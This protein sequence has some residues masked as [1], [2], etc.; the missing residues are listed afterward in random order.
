MRFLAVIILSAVLFAS[1][2]PPVVRAQVPYP[3]PPVTAPPP[4]TPVPPP[5]PGQQFAC[6]IFGGQ[7]TTPTFAPVTIGFQVFYQ[8]QG[9]RYWGG[10]AVQAVPFGFYS[11]YRY[12]TAAPSL[13]NGWQF[14]AGPGIIISTDAADFF[15]V[16]YVP[17]VPIY[18]PP[19]VTV[20]PPYTQPL[21]GLPAPGTPAPPRTPTGVG[22][23]TLGFAQG[24]AVAGWRLQYASGRTV[25]QCHTLAAPEAG[26][27]TDGVISPNAGDL[28]LAPNPCP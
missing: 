28:T 11:V 23:F 3:P 6:P 25:W 26:W 19:P 20:P 10:I 18:P 14:S 27:V 12:A 13:W 16:S 15:P 24:W 5:L 22:N 9:C 21:P 4:T 17:G 7:Q 1:V 2:G 8:Q